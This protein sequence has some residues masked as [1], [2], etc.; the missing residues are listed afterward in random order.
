MIVKL[1]CIDVLIIVYNYFRYLHNNNEINEIDQLNNENL[2][3][4]ISYVTLQRQECGFGFRIVGG[5]EEFS[6]VNH[7]YS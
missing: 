3:S 5:K 4:N 6:Q 2:K 7:N 1:Y